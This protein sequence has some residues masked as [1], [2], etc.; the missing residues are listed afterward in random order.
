MVVTE[1]LQY[2]SPLWGWMHDAAPGLPL[3]GVARSLLS[4]STASL[5]STI[6][7]VDMDMHMH[8]CMDVYI[9]T[10][11]YI[12]VYVHVYIHVYIMYVYI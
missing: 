7:D 4:R 9:Y 10:H 6:M 5:P 11:I 2:L 1:A 8:T 12:Y 3:Q